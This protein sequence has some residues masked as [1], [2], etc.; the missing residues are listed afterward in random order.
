MMRP[1]PAAAAAAPEENQPQRR[2]RPIP[3]EGENGLFTQTWFPICL[4]SEVAKGQVI[5]R[6]FLDGRVAVYRGE[7]GTARVMSAY[8]VHLGADLAVGSVVGNRLQCRFHKWEYDADGRCARTGLGDPVPPEACIFRFP[9]VERW[10]LIWAF[11]GVEPLFE[12]PALEYPDEA[13][14]VTARLTYSYD[15]DPWVFSANTFDFQHFVLLHGLQLEDG[16]PDK[17]I[18]WRPFDVLYDVNVRHWGDVKVK[19][20]YGTIGSNIF[21]S[22]G[23]YDGRWYA[24]LAPRG[25]PKPGTAN[26]FLTVLT[27]KGDGSPA[28]LAEAERF[29]RQIIEMEDKFVE[30]DRAILQSIRFKQGYL[31]RSDKALAKFL[32][33]IR[34]YP[35]AHP[36]APFIR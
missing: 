34:H 15:D 33:H 17:D 3:R 8:C 32:D 19:F 9:T 2:W 1:T 5:G 11:N 18:R 30:Q 14:H 22:Q 36:S 29:N 24:Y 4:G 23:L 21:F 27:H 16:F 20:T 25:L 35:R 7:D 28:A 10:G 12:L 6:S 13:L 31:T 26:V